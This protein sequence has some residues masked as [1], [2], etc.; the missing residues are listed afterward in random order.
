MF[1]PRSPASLR[2]SLSLTATALLSL[3]THAAEPQP[4]R[5]CM[6]ENNAPFS[7]QVKREMRGLDLAIAQAVADRVQRPLKIVPFE[8]ELE[9]ESTLSQEVNAML[10]SDVCDLASGFSLLE[11][12][13]GKPRKAVSKTPEYPGAKRY[14]ERPWITLGTLVASRPYQAVTMTLVTGKTE[15]AQITLAQPGEARLGAL[16]GTVGGAATMLYD[17][18]KWRARIVNLSRDDDPFQ[19]LQDDRADAILVSQSR[20]DNWRRKHPDSPIQ[21]TGYVHPMRL[22]LGLVALAENQSLLEAANATIE[23]AQA[24]GQ[25]AQWAN[26]AQVTYVQPQE[27][28]VSGG[29]NI[30]MLSQVQ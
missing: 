22:N 24:S 16:A 26:A 3:S 25:M 11:Q 10:S 9:D 30:A 7:Y 2:V 14:K 12:D 27:P 20:L 17:H 15:F 6:A 23:A 29:P 21:S 5:V 4:L 19:V 13:L 28:F 8:S 18:G 1:K